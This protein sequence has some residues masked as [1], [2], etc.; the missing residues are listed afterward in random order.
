MGLLSLIHDKLEDYA[1]YCNLLHFLIQAPNNTWN[2]LGI[3][4]LWATTVSCLM[5]WLI[6]DFC[7][8]RESHFCLIVCLKGCLRLWPSHF[9]ECIAQW[10][11]LFCCD[12]E[13]RHFCFCCRRH[14][15]FYYLCI[16][17]IGPLSFGFGSFSD[18]K[19]CAPA[20]LLAVDSFKNPASAFASKIISLFLNSM[21][22]LGYV[23]T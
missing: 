9:C 16:V 15:S 4:F 10:Y 3:L 19:M 7:F 1:W 12:E 11:H 6:F 2:F 17:N 14:H 13:W 23:D 20:L 22:S 5:I 21:P 8:V 18:R